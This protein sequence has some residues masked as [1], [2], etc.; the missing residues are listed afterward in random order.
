MDVSCISP[1]GQGEEAVLDGRESN[2]V[3][4]VAHFQKVPAVGFD[5]QASGAVLEHQ[6]GAELVVGDGS[7]HAHPLR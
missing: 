7:P 4:H 2:R 3:G 5:P 6:R 1:L